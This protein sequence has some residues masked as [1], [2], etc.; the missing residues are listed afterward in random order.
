MKTFIS[1]GFHSRVKHLKR[2]QIYKTGETFEKTKKQDLA[3]SRI[4]QPIKHFVKHPHRK[5]LEQAVSC[6]AVIFPE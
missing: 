3:T 5:L 4:S 6:C 1:C 2:K